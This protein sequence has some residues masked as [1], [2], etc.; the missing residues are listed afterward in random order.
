MATSGL[1]AVTS[2][3]QF[4]T[5]VD[6]GGDLHAVR[7]QQP[8]QPVPQQEEVFG[9]DNTHGTSMVT[10][11]GPP[12]GLETASTPSNA[13]QPTLDSGQ[14][15][16]LRRVRAAGPVVADGDAQHPVLV[17]QVNPRLAEGCA[18]LD[19]L[20]SSSLTAK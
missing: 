7:F 15:G 5:V 18:C 11:V 13:A 17:P 16:A 9:D 10:M 8:G 6:G 4:S 12:G 19:T 2:A 14:P 1:S 20:A 3:E